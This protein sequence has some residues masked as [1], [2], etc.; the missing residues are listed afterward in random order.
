MP[1]VLFT[2]TALHI[3][4]VL[5]QNQKCSINPFAQTIVF[6]LLLISHLNGRRYCKG[7]YALDFGHALIQNSKVVAGKFGEESSASN[8]G[9]DRA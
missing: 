6:S 7:K 4:Y 5:P 3:L 9:G 8:A 2:A 1:I